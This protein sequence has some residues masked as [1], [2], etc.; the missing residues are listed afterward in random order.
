MKEYEQQFG[1]VVTKN[2]EQVGREDNLLHVPLPIFYCFF[3]RRLMGKNCCVCMVVLAISLICMIDAMATNSGEL[4]FKAAESSNMGAVSDAIKGKSVDVNAADEQGK[5]LLMYAAQSG[6]EQLVRYLISKGADVRKGQ[7]NLWDPGQDITVLY[8]AALDGNKSL[9]KYLIEEEKLDPRVTMLM[10]KDE[11]ASSA[12]S[13]AAA[14]SSKELAEYLFSQ[15][16]KQD[17]PV[18]LPQALNQ[19]GMKRDREMINY[20]LSV[21]SATVSALKYAL[22]RAG[23]GREK[24]DLDFAAWLLNKGVNPNLPVRYG[25]SGECCALDTACRNGDREMAELLLSFGADVNISLIGHVNYTP[26]RSAAQSGNLDL[27]KFLIS[28]GARINQD[29]SEHESVLSFAAKSGNNE[30]VQFF[31]D[32]GVPLKGDS[33]L[34]EAICS[35]K[36]ETVD[37]LLAAGADVNAAGFFN[38]NPLFA[39]VKVNDPDIVRLLLKKGAA[40]DAKNLDGQT[41]MWPVVESAASTGDFSIMKYL[42]SRKADLKARDNRGN[43]LLGFADTRLNRQPYYE[44][45]KHRLERAG[46]K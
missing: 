42:I 4:I 31:I 44:Q 29:S 43:S 45:L 15:I 16:P 41:V 10:R 14:S 35:R 18:M 13:N 7:P 6:N 11:F 20:L 36:K 32:N 28:K 3:N 21:D 33:C 8:Y 40:I 39:A 37:Y 30:V 22:E 27:V 9:V 24:D 38:E 25:N 46:A 19:A 26:L 23:A 12:L 5:T 1:V 2:I 17:V 34:V